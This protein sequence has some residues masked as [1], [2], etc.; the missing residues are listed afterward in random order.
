MFI[1]TTTYFT[2]LLLTTKSIPSLNWS[3]NII[4]I[5]MHELFFC[6]GFRNSNYT[7]LYFNWT[8]ILTE[9]YT[10]LYCY[11]TLHSIILY[12]IL[13]S[14]VLLVLQNIINE[15]SKLLFF[16]TKQRA[17]VR[18]IDVL[19]PTTFPAVQGMHMCMCCVRYNSFIHLFLH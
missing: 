2:V 8:C 5:I 16:S 3:I 9:Q 19:L 10:L 4:S 15:F 14:I 1:W 18:K 7:K 11:Y 12:Y 17:Y 6:P 13:Y